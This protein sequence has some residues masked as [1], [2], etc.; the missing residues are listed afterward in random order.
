MS[1][2]RKPA[3]WAA[4]LAV[5]L[6]AATVHADLVLVQKPL[7]RR[8]PL[9][10]CPFETRDVD[11]QQNAFG[12]YFTPTT[13]TVTLHFKIANQNEFGSWNANRIDNIVV[14]S[15]T[16]FE[17]NRGVPVGFADCYS[18]PLPGFPDTG[19]N[20]PAF[21]FNRFAPGTL[22]FVERFDTTPAGDVNR[23]W[24]L[25]HGA[26][27]LPQ[28]TTTDCQDLSPKPSSAPRN[29]ETGSDCANG[30]LAMGQ[31]SDGDIDITTSIV[32][33]GLSPGTEYIV[34][35]WWDT[36]D[37]TLA[38]PL[39]VMVTAP[40]VG[41][42]APPA[43]Q[44][45]RLSA[46]PNPFNPSTRLQFELPAAGLARLVIV[47]VAGR[48]VRTLLHRALD[49]GPHERLWDGRTDAGATVGSGVY[50]A[51]LH[52]GSHQTSHRLVLVR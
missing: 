5:G 4:G 36:N 31:A 2:S 24:D 14:V 15:R 41:S 21:F 44:S 27:F 16:L 45:L 52:A 51:R 33:N 8:F 30:S 12:L 11:P 43:G 26:Y 10:Y 3:P 13:A 32:V 49:A 6:L 29:P 22:P 20:A 28:N 19:N 7:T 38:N 9:N 46:A 50:F 47:D 39:E 23:P 18:D 42:D 17:A 1:R 40:D 37:F 35:G 25:T 34:T 48:H